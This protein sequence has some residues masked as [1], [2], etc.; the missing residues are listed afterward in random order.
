MDKVR[1]IKV[2]LDGLSGNKLAL[3]ETLLDKAEFMETELNKL[4]EI[5]KE[6]G[7]VE[8]YQNGANQYGL[9]KSTEGD[10]YNVMIKNYNSTIKQLL[11][12]LPDKVEEEEDDLRRDVFGSVG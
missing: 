12:I 10:V 4:Q 8:S 3:A 11:D 5:I 9:K 1:K 7:W 2:K 6:K